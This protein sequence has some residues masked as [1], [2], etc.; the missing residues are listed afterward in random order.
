MGKI[1]EALKHAEAKRTRALD[2]VSLPRPPGPA[3]SKPVEDAVS[4]PRPGVAAAGKPAEDAESS[5]QP[6]ESNEPEIPFIEVGGPHSPMVASASVLA[7][8]PVRSKKAEVA[9]TPVKPE[10]IPAVKASGVVVGAP[11]PVAVAFQ[12]LPVEPPVLPPAPERFSS[13]LVTFHRP[14][15]SVSEQYRGL[16][17]SLLAQ[18]PA[19]RAQVLLLTAAS[20][21]AGTTTALLNL[22]ITAARSGKLRVVVVDADMRRPAIAKRLGLPLA[23]GLHEVL[24]GTISL[25]RAVQETG[26]LH[27]HV[28]T[29][30]EAGAGMSR[31]AGEAMRSVLRH[32]RNR[33]DL[34]LV[35]TVPWDGRPDVVALGSYCDS[36]YVVVRQAEAQ[37]AEI[38]ELFQVIPQQGSRLRGC[39][40]TQC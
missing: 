32:L 16:L 22:G 15:H 26:Q 13:D 5:L 10:A 6:E 39:I 33:F 12:P 17:K 27:L 7:A 3:A 20:A 37:K 9:R 21:G 40:L 31:L 25:Q 34:T 28:L 1:L 18:V 8:S 35:D 19:G 14:D 29:A 36:V 30:G 11:I 24:A 4:L 23:P 2:A 38:N